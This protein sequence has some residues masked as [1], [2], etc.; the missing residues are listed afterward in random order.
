MTD[1]LRAVL[2]TLG[3]PNTLTGGY[4]YHRRMAEL[5]PRHGARL[6]FASFPRRP[7]P[8]AAADAP[9]V[10]ARARALGAQVLVLDS[11]A[12][13]FCGPLFAVRGPGLPIVGMLHQP[14]GGIDYGGVRRA[15]QSML[16]RMAYRRVP[17]L[18]VAAD[19]LADEM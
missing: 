16:D 5:A 6:D 12:A 13:A 19:A 9:A 2:I 14:P 3:D 18:M 8:L 15:A 17:R 7:F 10:L 11:I 1:P 4:L